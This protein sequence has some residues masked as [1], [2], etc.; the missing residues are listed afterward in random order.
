MTRRITSLLLCV[1]LVMACMLI[2]NEP[3]AAADTIPEA[4]LDAQEGIVHVYLLFF[5]DQQNLIAY[6]SGAGIV[7]A[8]A[9]MMGSS[10]PNWNCMFTSFSCVDVSGMTNAYSRYQMIVLADGKVY[11]VDKVGG[12][13]DINAEFALLFMSDDISERK[14]I[15]LA[16][17]RSLKA[18][19]IV[20]A[21]GFP[22][23]AD[24]YT[25]GF[26]SY[27]Q[28]EI[29]VKGT[30]QD[31]NYAD[32]GAMYIQTDIQ[33]GRN[34]VG[35]ALV[36]SEGHL[37]GLI[38]SRNGTKGC[39]AV[40][41]DDITAIL[42]K[43]NMPIAFGKTEDDAYPL[44]PTPDTGTDTRSKDL[45]SFYT[46]AAAA[47]FKV[48]SN[49]DPAVARN[50]F[51]QNANQGDP[52]SKTVLGLRY[53]PNYTD[54]Q[55]FE[56]FQ[57]AAAAG[58]APAIYSL[59]LCYEQGIGVA[60]D[61]SKSKELFTQAADMLFG[62]ENVTDPV[63]A[64]TIGECYEYGDGKFEQDL[65]MAAT[66]YARSGDL[67]EPAGA[68][69]VGKMIF[70]GK[71]QG[72]TEDMVK[73]FA[74]AKNAGSPEGTFWYALMVMVGYADGDATALMKTAA[75]GGSIQ[76]KLYLEKGTVFLF[77]D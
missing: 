22:E 23:P 47:A 31:L 14:T 17:M 63:V 75:E 38:S 62:I 50:L 20:Y 40:T 4:V 15:P 24:P 65:G 59:A 49:G 48:Y 77:G 5:D 42:N 12:L 2:S 11:T 8:G 9:M 29:I 27:C 68:L 60:E 52:F 16:Q 72:N 33:A 28:E 6:N 66:W 41:C 64:Y 10:Q 54:A 25:P 51:Q 1:C 37:V 76:A 56:M 57:E 74:K 32:S 19:D 35:G 21:I 46:S 18:G 3:Q 43:A 53:G 71:V 34:L 67:G 7:S 26:E 36:N 73:W 58:Y 69:D 61:V 39:L 70:N 30:I 45:N 13:P 55:R 44:L